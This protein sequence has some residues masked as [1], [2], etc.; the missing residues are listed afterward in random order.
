M[1]WKGKTKERQRE[2]GKELRFDTSESLFLSAIL[3]SISVAS[4]EY[5]W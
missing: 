3:E 5:V 4:V 1:V 2:K